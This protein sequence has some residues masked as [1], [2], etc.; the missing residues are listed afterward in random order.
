MF[1]ERKFTVR[2]QNLQGLHNGT[3]CKSS[4]IN[5]V[6]GCNCAN[7][8]NQFTGYHSHYVIPQKHSII[9]KKF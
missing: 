9:S 6:W 2:F 5:E 8:Q 3:W 4:K 1:P 7:D